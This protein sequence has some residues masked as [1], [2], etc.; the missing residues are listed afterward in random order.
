M[1]DIWYGSYFLSLVRAGYAVVA[2]DYA[3]LGAETGPAEFLAKRAHAYDTLFSFP[4]ARKAVPQLG[5]EWLAIG[6]S[7]GGYA[8]LATDE[9]IAELRRRGDPVGG[10]RGAAAVAPVADLRGAFSRWTAQPQSAGLATLLVKGATASGSRLKASEILSTEALRRLPVLSRG[11]LDVI[12]AV[13]SDLVEGDLI[14]PGGLRKLEP[15]L[16]ANEPGTR[17]AGPLLIQ[18]GSADVVVTELESAA[19]VANLRKAGASVT[20]Q[21]YPDGDHLGVLAQSLP[22]TLTWIAGRFSS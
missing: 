14:R 16:R 17:T 2:T 21:T 19:L 11:C 9:L 20:Y 7:Q 6:H 12:T 18:Q 10:Y 1:R 22:E 13:Y 15:F 8:V 5:A 4:A 3:G